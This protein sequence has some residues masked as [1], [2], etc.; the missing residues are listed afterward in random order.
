MTDPQ[1]LDFLDEHVKLKEDPKAA[2]VFEKVNFGSMLLKYLQ[3]LYD[4]YGD[5]LNLNYIP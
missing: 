2:I 1:I 5:K 3:S 4:K